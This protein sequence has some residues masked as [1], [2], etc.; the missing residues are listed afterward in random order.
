MA[1][2]AQSLRRSLRKKYS[3]V[4]FAKRFS[5]QYIGSIDQ[6][7]TS[8]RFILFD[9][10]GKIVESHQVEHKQILPQPG[11]VFCISLEDIVALPSLILF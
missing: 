7:T 9:V 3:T 6:G 1:H 10:D 11:F 5:S 4:N 8:T 2:A